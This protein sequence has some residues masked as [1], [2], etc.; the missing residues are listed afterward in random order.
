MHGNR[1]RYRKAPKSGDNVRAVEGSMTFG[2]KYFNSSFLRRSWAAVKKYARY[3]LIVVPAVLLLFYGIRYAIARAYHMELDNISYEAEHK[4]ISR[5]QA[6]DL[7][8]IHDSINLTELN[9]VDW[10]NRLMAHP[11]IASAHIHAE[12]PDTLHIEVEERIPVVFVEMESGAGTGNRAKLYMD[13]NGRLF[14]IVPEFHQKF[15]NL[16]VW[17][18]QAGDLAEFKP[19]ADVAEK[20]YRPIVELAAAANHYSLEEIPSIKEIFRPKEWKIILTLDNGA[21]VLMQVYDIKGQMERLAMII[22]HAA[23]VGKRPVSIDVI[24]RVNPTVIYAKEGK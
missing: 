19:G 3:A 14:P 6:L 10:E 15:T 13:Q 8:G 5:E 20:A 16:P 21:E 22:E 9:P 18:L 4:I 7:L 23:A 1:N 17:Y 12:L 24:P 11:C 2:E